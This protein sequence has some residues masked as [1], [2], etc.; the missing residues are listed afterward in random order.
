MTSSQIYNYADPVSEAIAA[1]TLAAPQ[2]LSD[3]LA[4]SAMLALGDSIAVSLGALEF[5]AAVYARNYAALTPV[6]DGIAIWGTTMRSTPDIAALVNGVLLRCYD[7]NDFYV[8]ERNS[9]HPS[10]MVSGILAAAEFAGISG[11]KTLAA[12]AVGYEGV[13]VAYDCFSTAPGGWDYT[14]LSAIGS[15]I[16]IAKV[17]GLDHEQTREAIGMTVVNHMATDE[18]ESCELNRRGDLTMWKRFNGSDAVRNA[19]QACMLASVGVEAAVRP[20]VGNQGFIQKLKNDPSFADDAVKGFKPGAPLTVIQKAYFKPWP[21]GSLAQST[22]RAVLEARKKVSSLDDIKQMRVYCE[23]GAYEHF[24]TMRQDAWNP[25]SRE[26]ADHSMPYVAAAALFDGYIKIDSYDLDKVNDPARRSF[27]ANKMT[28]EPDAA[29]GRLSDGKLSRAERGYLGR[30]EIEMNDGSII[31][32][33]ALPF[34]GHPA[35]PF[36][37]GEL[38]SKLR[39]NMD[40][41]P[42]EERKAM[43][44]KRLFEFRSIANVADFNAHLSFNR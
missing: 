20:F 13:G 44:I 30:V 8:G 1:F 16:G 26:T 35:R 17:L 15:C 38:E 42:T 33:P 14:N 7:Y 32:G 19:L 10:D 6:P 25:I 23:E 21:T 11:E 4:E 12:L 3:D 29:L 28:V 22:I 2:K 36:T 24:V 40:Y 27:M 31:E 39:A 43:I 5:P 18:V 41:V 9:G 37:R 34:P